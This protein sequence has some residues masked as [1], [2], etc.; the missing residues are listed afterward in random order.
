MRPAPRDG[1]ASHPPLVFPARPRWPL[2]VRA[3]ANLFFSSPVEG[4]LGNVFLDARR[5]KPMDRIVA[6]QTMPDLGGRDVARDRIEHIDR[7]A[8]KRDGARVQ[9][10]LRRTGPR[11]QL[12]RNH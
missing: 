3:E 2:E 4:L 12:R 9:R 5:Y 6:I 11:K 1:A 8:A 7:R 10:G